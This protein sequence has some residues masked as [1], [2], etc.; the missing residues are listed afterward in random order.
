[1]HH[2]IYFY[3]IDKMFSDLIHPIWI[4]L[5]ILQIAFTINECN[6]TAANMICF[7]V[8]TQLLCIYL[9][10]LKLKASVSTAGWINNTL[11]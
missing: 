8:Y 11:K 7:Y 4:V 5:T 2:N 9:Y 6:M 1:M 3:F 10:N